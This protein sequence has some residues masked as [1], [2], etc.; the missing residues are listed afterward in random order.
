MMGT[1]NS[2]MPISAVP[3]SKQ[4]IQANIRTTS[5]H[6]SLNVHINQP[7]TSPNDGVEN[8]KFFLVVKLDPNEIGRQTNAVRLAL[9]D[10]NLFGAD[11]LNI[12]MNKV[13]KERS[14]YQ[15]ELATSEDKQRLR[16]CLV[17]RGF[18]CVEQSE[19]EAVPQVAAKY[20]IY[21][22]D[23]TH[24]AES[25]KKQILNQ[26]RR[27]TINSSSFSVNP[28]KFI[29][30]NGTVAML[31]Y[32]GS[33]AEEIEKNPCHYIETE[34]RQLVK[35]FPIIFC[36]RCCKLD[37]HQNWQTCDGPKKCFKCAEQTHTG[38]ECTV[39]SYKDYNCVSK[40]GPTDKKAKHTA[41]SLACW[42]RK[43]ILKKKHEDE[44]QRK[45]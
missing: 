24:T 36:K 7:T 21:G 31:E 1:L 28:N 44:K 5:I 14:E 4:T 27:Q 22:F 39:R 32:R 15:F 6:N 35:Y 18:E 41:I 33:A 8:E 11:R 12:K 38:D 3:A 2:V 37:D 34:C 45:K 19:G 43:D 10:D 30:Q 26:E 9:R 40:F 13:V 29:T 17:K 20:L 23:Y 25:L 42:T 16:E